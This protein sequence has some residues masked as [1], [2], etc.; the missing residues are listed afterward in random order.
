MIHSI[1]ASKAFFNLSNLTIIL[2]T[3]CRPPCTLH[4]VLHSQESFSLYSKFSRYLDNHWAIASCTWCFWYN[5]AFSETL[6]DRNS[7]HSL[8]VLCSCFRYY[9]FIRSTHTLEHAPNLF[10]HLPI[11]LHLWKKGNWN[12]NIDSRP[13]QPNGK[14]GYHR[15]DQNWWIFNRLHW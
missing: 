3:V 15:L 12:G 8:N 5:L 10:Y 4:S 11:L 2:S 1:L 7:P 6:I 14:C 9:S 13:I